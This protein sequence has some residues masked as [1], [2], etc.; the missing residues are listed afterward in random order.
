MKNNF[1]I[2]RN[3]VAVISMLFIF[4]IVGGCT[5]RSSN[6]RLNTLIENNDVNGIIELYT[7][8]YKKSNSKIEF[9]SDLLKY[10]EDVYDDYNK[11]KITYEDGREKYKTIDEVAD[12]LDLDD[13]LSDS[14]DQF[15]NL[16]SSKENF[17]KGKEI[18]SK[19]RQ[20]A[21]GN[22]KERVNNAALSC[23]DKFRSV[24]EEDINYSKADKLQEEASS[25]YR[26]YGVDVK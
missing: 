8:Q 1:R 12:Y 16:K 11:D 9:C 24:C 6:S 26:Y 22:D 4:T 17:E 2:L 19:L 10:E 25:Y 20:G 3:T 15:E 13:R 5:E 7:E 18:L 21:Y 14:F 23:M